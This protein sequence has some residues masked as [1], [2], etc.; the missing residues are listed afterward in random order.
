MKSPFEPCVNCCSENV[1]A[2]RKAHVDEQTGNVFL[3]LVCQ[4]CGFENP[5]G[6][7]LAFVEEIRIPTNKEEI[8]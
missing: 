8:N 5:Y 2:K 4:D 3:Q 6:A 1:R 7:E